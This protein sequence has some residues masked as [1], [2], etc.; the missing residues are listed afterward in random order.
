MSWLHRLHLAA[1]PLGFAAMNAVSLLA[2]L[3]FEGRVKAGAFQ[4]M[5]LYAA[6][7]PAAYRGDLSPFSVVLSGPVS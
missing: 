5:L 6:S 4:Y 3:L 7:V 1:L 2:G